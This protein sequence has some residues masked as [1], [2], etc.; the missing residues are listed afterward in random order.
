MT[1]AQKR[2]E[3]VH[4]SLSRL[5]LRALDEVVTLD[6]SDRSTVLRTALLGYLKR[7]WAE[8]QKK[9]QQRRAIG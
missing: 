1:I 8:P 7:R 6:G 5:E 4:S 9:K 2:T 3:R